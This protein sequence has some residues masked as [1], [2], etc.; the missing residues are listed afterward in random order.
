M[1]ETQI[2]QSQETLEDRIEEKIRIG[3]LLNGLAQGIIPMVIGAFGG[4]AVTQ[5]PGGASV[6]LALT[7]YGMESVF[8]GESKVAR[9][10]SKCYGIGFVVGVSTALIAC[11]HY[12]CSSPKQ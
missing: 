1:T 5:G 3:Q 9:V 6:G 2:Q 10:A 8:P 11:A 4:Y 12:G 7:A